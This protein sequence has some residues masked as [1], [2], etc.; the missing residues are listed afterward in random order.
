[1][2]IEEAIEHWKFI[3]KLLEKENKRQLEIC[4]YLYIEGFTHGHKH[5]QRDKKK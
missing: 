5:G 2:D 4:E 1:M 3:E